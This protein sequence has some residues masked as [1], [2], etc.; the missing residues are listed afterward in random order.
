MPMQNTRL[1][2]Q[3]YFAPKREIKKNSSPIDTAS[4][5]IRVMKYRISPEK[6]TQIAN[7]PKMIGE[8]GV[9]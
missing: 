8:F 9:S 2:F 7:S 3:S 4:T 6:D 5:I 1:V